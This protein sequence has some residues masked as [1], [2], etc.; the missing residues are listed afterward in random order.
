M[1]RASV[2]RPPRRASDGGGPSFHR[3]I[4]RTGTRPGRHI[5]ARGVDR[6]S[7]S[8]CHP[9]LPGCSH[10]V[11]REESSA[12]PDDLA[13]HRHAAGALHSQVRVRQLAHLDQCSPATIGPKPCRPSLFGHFH[14]TMPATGRARERSA[15]AVSKFLF[16]CSRRV[17]GWTDTKSMARESNHRP[18]HTVT[19]TIS[20]M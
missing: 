6:L 1:C 12:L 13:T 16:V 8:S 4:P 19:H 20:F 15:R 17:T 7:R 5:H 18:T 11:C 9:G 10:R 14:A 3:A 2:G